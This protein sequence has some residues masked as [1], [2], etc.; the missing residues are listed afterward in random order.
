MHFHGTLSPKTFA[1][2]VI[3]P[4]HEVVERKLGGAPLIWW[5]TKG[6]YRRHVHHR[7]RGCR[8]N[9]GRNQWFVTPD[10]TACDTISFTTSFTRPTP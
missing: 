3:H 10:G 8:I 9:W 2:Q 7:I 1:I 6:V 5:W 4:Q